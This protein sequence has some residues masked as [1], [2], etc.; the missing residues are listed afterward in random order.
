MKRLYILLIC[1]AFLIVS[2]KKSEKLAP[3]KT[4]ADL[5]VGNWN[6]G[7]STYTY[8]VN[9][10]VVFHNTKPAPPANSYYYDFTSD[11]LMYT[12]DN[13]NGNYIVSD[14]ARY[15]VADSTLYVSVIDTNKYT[16]KL[17][18][19]TLAL[20]YHV[21]GRLYYVGFNGGATAD[22]ETDHYIFIRR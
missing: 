18:K 12:Y 10:N 11:G 19:D 22:A 20:T 16:V 3:S 2:C 15:H 1:S 9:G 21:T 7:P 14:E 6:F 13:S 4:I 5:I 8:Y 17:N